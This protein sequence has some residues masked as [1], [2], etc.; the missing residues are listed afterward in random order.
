MES[1]RTSLELKAIE[2]VRGDDM[3]HNFHVG[4]QLMKQADYRVLHG[5][6]MKHFISYLDIM[7]DLDAR[8]PVSPVKIREKLGDLINYFILQEMLLLEKSDWVA[9]E[10]EER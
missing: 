4:A 7:D 6:M 2:Y 5:F 1:I 9:E 10:I 8:K 3:M